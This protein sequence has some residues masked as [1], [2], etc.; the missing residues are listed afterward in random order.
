MFSDFFFLF[1]IMSDLVVFI[2]LYHLCELIR[3]IDDLQ[4]VAP[5]CGTAQEQASLSLG[6]T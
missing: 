4:H 2:F 5:A 6:V 3:H 1:I